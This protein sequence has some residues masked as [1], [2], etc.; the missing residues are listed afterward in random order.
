MIIDT[1]RLV[2]RARFTLKNGKVYRVAGGHYTRSNGDVVVTAVQVRE[3]RAW[4][5]YGPVRP[6][7]VANIVTI[8]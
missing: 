7:K 4:A 3:D 8:L 6:I 2:Q 1:I 5:D